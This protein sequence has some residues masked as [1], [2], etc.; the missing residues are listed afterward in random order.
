MT[1][2]ILLSL[3]IIKNL[4]YNICL[5]KSDRQTPVNEQ[6]YKVILKNSPITTSSSGFR[7][8]YHLKTH[9]F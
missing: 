4:Y 8:H 5:S 6:K 9:Y 3:I 7:F 1:L 2:N